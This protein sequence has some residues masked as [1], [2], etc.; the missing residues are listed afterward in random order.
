[1]ANSVSSFSI[2]ELFSHGRY[3]IPPYQRNYAWGER[4]I[5]QLIQDIADSAADN[6]STPYHIGT[7]IVYERKKDGETIYETIDGQQRLTTL[8][9]LLSAIKQ[10]HGNAIP[11]LEDWYRMNLSF[12]SRQRSTDTLD[13]LYSNEM[14]RSLSF[15]KEYN[16]D[17]LQGYYD[18]VKA[19]NRILPERG[20]AMDNFCRYLISN[21]KIL[22]VTVPPDTDLNHYFEIM[23]N[24][25]EQLEKHEILKAKFLSVFKDDAAETYCFN[26]LWESCAN[27]ERYVQYGFNVQERNAVFTRGD[28]DKMA[29]NDFDELCAVLAAL[30]RKVRREMK[31]N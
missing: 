13:A 25:G 22:R 30:A 1:M 3:V 8:N 19:L 24:R 10:T 7:L 16:P 2:K 9:I 11:K 18:S 31:Q 29:V 12:D 23:N 5:S 6:P 20:V 21:V 27:M 28:W 14:E 17:I 26:I 15:E 4:E